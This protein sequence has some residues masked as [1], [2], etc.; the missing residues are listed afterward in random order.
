R[1]HAAGAH[2]PGA[3]QRVDVVVGQHAV[4]LR[5]EE[6]ARLA[7]HD[8]G[9]VGTRRDLWRDRGGLVGGEVVGPTEDAGAGLHARPGGRG[10]APESGAAALVLG[11]AQV[12]VSSYGNPVLGSLTIVIL[13]VIILRFRTITI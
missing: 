8:H 3:D 5:P 7:L 1:S 9:L 2:H 6:R 11:G 10:V 4:K 12:L 13:A